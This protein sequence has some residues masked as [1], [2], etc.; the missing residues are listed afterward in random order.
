MAR[1]LL[2]TSPSFGRIEKESGLQT[3]NGIRLLWLVANELLHTFNI[4]KNG[5]AVG[6]VSQELTADPPDPDEGHW[7]S[8]M[9]DGTGTGDD[10]DILVKITAGGST[11]T[12]TLLD[13]SSL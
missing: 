2:I 8:W 11:K 3:R 10:G 7:V 4:F 1:N 6:T 9:G 5:F 13:F 12:T